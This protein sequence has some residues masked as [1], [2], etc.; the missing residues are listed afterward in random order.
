MR[1]NLENG[2]HKMKGKK[3]T[4]LSIC[5][6]G[7]ILLAG[8]TK[9]PETKPKGGSGSGKFFDEILWYFGRRFCRI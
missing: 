2:M 7:I 9:T 6:I 8:C 1:T 3:L 4:F 5:L